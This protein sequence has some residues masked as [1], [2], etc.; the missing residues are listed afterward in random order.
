M[1]TR[2]KLEAAHQAAYE[3]ADDDLDHFVT[4]AADYLQVI[5]DSFDEPHQL[6]LALQH[7]K[8]LRNLMEDPNQ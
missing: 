7:M 2:D 6:P 5:I 1:T 4:K 3:A 8:A